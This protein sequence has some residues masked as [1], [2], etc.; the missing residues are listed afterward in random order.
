MSR[1]TRIHELCMDGFEKRFQLLMTDWVSKETLKRSYMTTR[2]GEDGILNE[3]FYVLKQ[4]QK[5]IQEAWLFVQMLRSVLTEMAFK[6]SLK[7][8]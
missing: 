1:L 2:A 3:M 7:G 5:S 6:E 4:Q 8:R